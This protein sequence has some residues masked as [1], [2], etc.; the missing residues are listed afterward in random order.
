[1]TEK[2]EWFE[3]TGDDQKPHVNNSVTRT[4]PKNRLI[5][6]LAVAIPLVIVG[7][8]MVF[9]EGGSEAEEPP[10]NS[11]TQNSIASDNS[12]VSDNNLKVNSSTVDAPNQTTNTTNTINTTKTTKTTKKGIGVPAPTGRSGDR[13]GRE[14]EGREG[15][16][17]GEHDGF[18]G[19]DD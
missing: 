17:H 19:D 10:S 2:P 12:T 11:V 1:M 18:E 3:L 16:E 7:S 8:A 6:I 15:G 4:A 14:H 5:R 13:E 9:A